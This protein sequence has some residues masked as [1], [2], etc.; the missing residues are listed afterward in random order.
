MKKIIFM[1][2]LF[3]NMNIYAADKTDTIKVD[4]TKIETLIRD[5]TTNSKGKPVT[6]YYF[7]YNK[8]LV[9]T[10]KTTVE[11]FDLCNRHKVKCNLRLIRKNGIAKRIIL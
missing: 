7:I 11:R 5:N 6:K 8:E 2:L 9:P 3:V 1:A 10:N 4:N